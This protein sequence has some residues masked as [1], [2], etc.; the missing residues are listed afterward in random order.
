MTQARAAYGAAAADC[1]ALVDRH[2]QQ[3]ENI[4]GPVDGDYISKAKDER[5]AARGWMRMI[6]DP[7]HPLSMLK[8][9]YFC[10]LDSS[11]AVAGHLWYAQ[12]GRD[13]QY[14]D[15][16]YADH[17]YTWELGVVAEISTF[18]SKHLGED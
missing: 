4:A 1:L 8:W 17:Y 9:F 16:D 13:T 12:H 6:L 7:S 3:S 11:V 14:Q 2:W 5:E 18:L 15:Q 10:L